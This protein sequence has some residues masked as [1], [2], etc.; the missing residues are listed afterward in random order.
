[1]ACRRL[2][3]LQRFNFRLPKRYTLFSSRRFQR[4]V[5]LYF[6]LLGREQGQPLYKMLQ[7]RT[8]S[9]QTQSPALT[10]STI[11]LVFTPFVNKPPTTLIMFSRIITAIVLTSSECSTKKTGRFAHLLFY[12]VWFGAFAAP[13]G[14][15]RGCH[16]VEACLRS[17][18]SLG[19]ARS[20]KSRYLWDCWRLD[21]SLFLLLKSWG[22][23]LKIFAWNSDHFGAR[24]L[25]S[26][27]I[28]W[29]LI[30]WR[31]LM[32]A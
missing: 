19:Y 25:T 2:L 26:C 14:Q 30:F 3:G 9:F 6:V 23:L 16:E 8:W 24:S 11:I 18:E 5:C 28:F 1:M 10:I 7:D 32:H 21:F 27:L 12:V 17:V 13:A 4:F 31:R 22:F 20:W 29:R 15:V